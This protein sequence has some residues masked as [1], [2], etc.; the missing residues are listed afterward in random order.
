MKKLSLTMVVILTITIAFAQENYQE[1][2]EKERS[3]K[4]GIKGGLNSAREMVSAGKVSG[5]T[6]V[7][8]GIHIGFFMEFPVSTTV[9][10]QPELLYS[11]QGGRYKDGGTNYTDKF[12]YINLPLMFKIYVWQRSLSIDFGPQLG[13]MIGAK[14]SIG[15]TN[16]D[17]YDEEALKK[18]D[19]SLALGLSFKLTDQLDLSFRG[20][21]GLTNILE[22]ESNYKNSVSQLSLAYRF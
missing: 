22:A 11:M 2:T 13:Y 19:A 15:G 3:F 7:R 17:I 12:D 14:I 8:T 5:Q 10:F 6:N 9:D 1:P 16:V 21:F 4:S 18:F 20:A